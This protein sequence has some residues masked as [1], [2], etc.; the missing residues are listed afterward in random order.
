MPH[1]PLRTAAVSGS[2]AA[3]AAARAVLR[4]V[5][6]LLAQHHLLANGPVR[7]LLE[8]NGARRVFVDR[9]EL[10][11]DLMSRHGQSPLVQQRQPT[12]E[13][14]EGEH[15]VLRRVEP[16]EGHLELIEALEVE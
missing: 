13:L 4:G 16:A 8:C 11:V 6:Q 15:A 5:R 12:L 9:G 2:A 14:C 1:G 3:A 10:G 7:Q